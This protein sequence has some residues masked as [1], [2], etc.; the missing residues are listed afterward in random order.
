MPSVWKCCTT[1]DIF[2]EMSPLMIFHFWDW[3]NSMRKRNGCRCEWMCQL[4]WDGGMI[5]VSVSHWLLQSRTGCEML[6]VW[7]CCDMV[8]FL[9]E[10]SPLVIF[11]LWLNEQ[12]AEVNGFMC[13]WVVSAE[14]RWRDDLSIGFRTDFCKAERLKCLVCENVTTGDIFTEMSPLGDIF[15]CGWMNS[16]LKWMN[17]CVNGCVS[18]IEMEEWSEYRFRI[19]CCK[20]EK[21]GIQSCLKM[22][23]TGDILTYMSPLVIFLLWLNE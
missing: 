5:W 17:A 7:K 16:M 4:D 19:D 8:T 23:Q 1:G 18:W 13:G 20:A 15:Y 14:L 9:T 3:M 11:L 22:S 12:L 6:S 10:M 2:T 21:A